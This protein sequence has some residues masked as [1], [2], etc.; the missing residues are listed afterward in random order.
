M[1]VKLTLFSEQ[2]LWRTP[3]RRPSVSIQLHFWAAYPITNRLPRTKKS[4]RILTGGIITP[5][6]CFFYRSV[7]FQLT[8][9]LQIS[10]YALD[11]FSNGITSQ[12]WSSLLTLTNWSFKWPIIKKIGSAKTIYSVTCTNTFN[13]QSL[14]KANLGKLEPNW[15]KWLPVSRPC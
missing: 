3:A 15:S 2:N 8:S 10:L 12:F 5:S 4:K 13:I 7:S 1:S 11:V 6:L 14:S 9:R